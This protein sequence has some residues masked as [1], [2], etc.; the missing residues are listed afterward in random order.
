MIFD[1]LKALIRSLQM[2]RRLDDDMDD[3]MRFHIEEYERDLVRSGL[4]GPEAARQARTEFGNISLT[5]ERCR[6]IKGVPMLDEFVRNINYAFRQLRRGPGFAV[7][8][9]LTPRSCIALRTAV[10]SLLNAR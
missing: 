1:G 6:E 5:K 8:R 7:T 9:I 4:P 2:R 10:F 3:E